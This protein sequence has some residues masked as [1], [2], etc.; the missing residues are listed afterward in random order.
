MLKDN[1]QRVSNFSGQGDP[2]PG[3]P[4]GDPTKWKRDVKLKYI[5]EHGKEGYQELIRNRSKEE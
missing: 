1:R 3:K 5:A 4:K 2:T